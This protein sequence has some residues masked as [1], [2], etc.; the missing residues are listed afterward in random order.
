M[1]F[2][3]KRPFSPDILIFGGKVG[4]ISPTLQKIHLTTFLLGGKESPFCMCF[5]CWFQGAWS[6]YTGCQLLDGG[7]QGRWRLAPDILVNFRVP[8][9]QLPYSTHRIHGTKGIFTYIL[10]DFYGKLVGTSFQWMFFH[11]PKVFHQLNSKVPRSGGA[12]STTPATQKIRVVSRQAVQC[13]RLR[14]KKNVGKTHRK[15][16]CV[17]WL[18]YDIL[19]ETN[20]SHLKIGWLEESIPRLPKT[21]YFTAVLT[22]TVY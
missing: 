17:L 5:C 7:I 13:S 15:N 19:P 12:A 8:M 9:F 21:V 16:T 2:L 6:G 10:G 4:Y 14:G 20:S 11:A 3:K 22:K 18:L 1:S